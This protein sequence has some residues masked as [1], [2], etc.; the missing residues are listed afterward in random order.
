MVKKLV[1]VESPAKAKTIQKYLGKGYE[2]VASMGH[3]RDLPKSTLGIDVE[4]DFTPKYIN[5]R[6]QS[7]TIKSLKAAAKRSDKIYLATDPDRE[8][9]AISWHL[10]HLL[11]GDLS[12]NNRVT[13]NEITKSGVKAG[14]A[15]PRKIDM[16]LVDAQQARRILDRIVGYK[17]SPLLWKK[18]RNGLSAGRVQSVAVKMIV[19]RE[20]EIR[21][22]V[23]QEFWTVDAK[24]YPAGGK[25]TF[26]AK[27][28]G[29]NGKKKELTCE[30][31]ANAVLEAVKDAPFTVTSVKRGVREKAPA[32]PFITSTLQQ[33]ASRRLGFQAKRTMKAAQELYE[34]V[35]VK[36]VGT[37]GLI[38]YMRTD[39]LRLS[40]E[41]KTA[42][43][44]FIAAHYGEGYL[45]SQPRN[46]K[47]KSSA[48]DAHEAIRPSIPSITPEQVKDSVTSDQYKL[49]KLIWER[50]MAC[51]MSNAVYDTVAASF[52]AN[53]MTFRASGYSVRFA[54]FTALYEE[55]SDDKEEESQNLPPL[56]EGD[57]LKAASV[58]SS[59]HF[60]QPPPRYTE[61]TLI[62]T[63]EENGIGRPSTYAPTITTIIARN[64]VERM[65]KQLAPTDLGEI[66]TNLM[67]EYFAKI[68]DAGFTAHLE[69]D[70]DTIADG[71]QEWKQVVRDFYGDFAQTLQYAEEHIGGEKIAVPDE[72]TDVICE[73][74]G[75][76]M[77]IKHGRYGKFLA[78]PGYP[79]CKN[80]KR[81][82][83]EADGACPLCGGKLQEYK[84][85]KGRKYYGCMNNPTCNFMTWDM[86]TRDNC[87]KCGKTLLHK[88]GKNSKF[89][90]SNPECDYERKES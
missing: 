1:I 31:E 49:Y 56:N 22:F 8:G 51:Q 38:T 64:Y 69:E 53:G 17:L 32:P 34:G 41:S 57:R 65:G 14:M 52:D 89:Y 3:V 54:G 20:E 62:K 67:N 74:C 86:P 23:P 12:E 61:A 75:R 36:G 7:D 48:Q 84:S 73:F 26:P 13:F 19:D 30:A 15:S 25:K 60:T 81:L 44:E 5:I 11:G 27:F 21:K 78:C 68:V 71:K 42:A 35:D 9:E 76:N 2:V 46:Y 59:Q 90:C 70:L 43:R 82:A 24:L 33:E 66:T 45:P 88:A 63:L 72:V 80:A 40:E 87:P 37:T 83:K 29:V 16:N 6:K 77:V 28:Y 18:V 58:T 47:S 4:N 79:S 39:S 10:A 55:K 85:K 50:F